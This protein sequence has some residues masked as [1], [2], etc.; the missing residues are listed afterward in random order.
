MANR[1]ALGFLLTFAIL[2]AEVAGGLASGSL[3]L[4]SDAGHVLTDLVALGLSWYGVKQAERRATFSMTYGYHRVGIFVALVNAALL[5]GISL[6]ILAEAF[7]RISEPAPVEGGLMLVVAAAGLAANLVVILALQPHARNLNVRSALLH[8][9]GDTLGSIAVVAG[10]LVILATGW[11]PIDPLAG[12]LIAVVIAFGSLRIIRESVNI[13]LE[14]T[15]GGVDVSELVR[16]IYAV[17]GI[18]DVHDLH[19]WSITPEIRA[20]S[21]HVSLDDVSISEGAA[22]LARLNEVLEKRFAIGHTT[23]QMEAEGCDPNELY[24]T[25]SPEGVPHHVAARAG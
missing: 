10:G 3:A 12:I 8:V 9:T 24:C 7:R 22:L 17:P 23:V 6:L 2:V 21:C 25:L 16:A 13:F 5:I 4:L 18:R 14:A 15:P 1:L 19:V 20:L 11:Y